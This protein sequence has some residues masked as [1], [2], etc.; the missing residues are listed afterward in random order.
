MAT[1][2]DLVHDCRQHLHNGERP[3]VNF[4]AETV[5]ST[6][7]DT[8]VLSL[9]LGPIKAGATISIG[10]ERMFVKSTNEAS[11][12]ATVQRGWDGSTAVT[13]TTVGTVVRVNEQY[14]DFAI[15]RALNQELADL[16][17][18]VNGLFKITSV[19][20][21]YAVTTWGYNL[22]AD[23]IG[24]PLGVLVEDP[25]GTANWRRLLPSEW[26][27]DPSADAT[28]FASG[29]SLRVVGYVDPGRTIRIV[30]REPFTAI[31]ALTDDVQTTV[32]LPA[33]ANDI[34]PLGAAVILLAGRSARRS[35]LDSQGSTRRA[36]ETSTQDALVSVRGLLARRE[37]RVAAEAA[38]LASQFAA[39]V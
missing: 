19:D 39:L 25:S 13:H 36:E 30:Y 32:G 7:D 17:S 6:S 38:R 12:T 15:V 4:L 23:M 29:K 22:D 1:A 11:K 33:S 31:S 3:Q 2:A 16:S 8:I 34:P 37:Q 27:Y 14:D 10:L 35:S 9:D 5:A 21:T 26:I 18:P 28:D 24:E 20:R